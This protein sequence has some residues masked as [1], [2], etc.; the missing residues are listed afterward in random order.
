MAEE[1]TLR[2]TI[3][4][5]MEAVEESETKADAPSE[6]PNTSEVSGS[7]ATH[8]ASASDEPSGTPTA[9]HG[10][11]SE[12]SGEPPAETAPAPAQAS[13][14]NDYLA[15]PPGTW[16]PEAREHWNTIPQA[17]REQVWKRDKE[18]SR[19]M[20]ESHQARQFV[21]EFQQVIQP[22]MGFI[23]AENS[24]PI[25]AVQNLMQTAAQLRGTKADRVRVVAEIIRNFDVDLK[26]LDDALV[27]EQPQLA[28]EDLIQRAVDQR[29]AP[30]QQYFN[31]QTQQQQYAGIRAAE[32]ELQAFAADPKHEFYD[33]VAPVMADLIEVAS[34][35]GQVLDLTAAYERATLLVEPVRRVLES[36][37]AASTAQQS[38]R[39]ANNARRAAV[40]V[41]GSNE[42]STVTPQP[43]DSIRSA[44]EHAF[45]NTGR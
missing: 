36:R 26:A 35:N 17:V 33:D 40:S 27:G 43:G 45:S 30:I 4:T 28:P 34:R 10:A 24:T 21:G 8:T 7:E 13:G 18:T 11:P 32:L 14:P 37:K 16:T 2:D 29:L 9:P 19:A 3:G 41:P 23:A 39:I 15:K 22:Y 38:Q 31:Q 1:M 25:R 12:Q 5:A 44:L 20:T 6:A 42:A